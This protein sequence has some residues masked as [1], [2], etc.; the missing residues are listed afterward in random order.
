MPPIQQLSQQVINQIAAGE[1]IER[2]A[3]VVKELLENSIDA[4]AKRID[5]AIVKGGVES[6]KI[7]DDGCGI[8]NDQLVLA[9]TS[10]A[11][12]KIR[13][14]QELFSVATMGFRGEALA[15]IGSVSHM[16]ISSRAENADAG[17]QLEING[18][19]FSAIEPCGMP[20]GTAVEIRDLFYN[21]PVRRKY[22]RTTQTEMSHIVEAFARVALAHCD[23]HFILRHNDKVVHDLPCTNNWCQRIGHFF[24]QE[25]EQSLIP[26]ESSDGDVSISGFVADPTQ[27]RGNNKLQYL[28]LNKRHIKDR[29]LQHALGE[30]YRG[31]LLT[32]RYPI[33]FLKLIVPTQW[34]DV[35]VHP[36]KLEVRF[37]DASRIYSQLLGTIREKFLT[38]DLTAKARLALDRLDTNHRFD[39]RSANQPVANAH[40]ANVFE[41]RQTANATEPGRSANYSDAQRNIDFGPAAHRD[42]TSRPA[43]SRNNPVP[44]GA[45]PTDPFP[46]RGNLD[47]HGRHNAEDGNHSQ[48]ASAPRDNASLTTPAPWDS[49]A[50]LYADQPSQT[51]N[52]GRPH[53]AANHTAI[54][55]HRKYLVTESDDGMVVIDQHALHE[56]ILYEQ[57]REKVL[58]GDL[59]TQA[60]LVPEPVNLS[61][62]ELELV[63]Q[64]KDQLAQIG[65]E[66]DHFGGKSVVVTGYP[67]MLSNINPSELLRFVLD[68][69]NEG[70]RKLEKRD[71][72]DE[73]LHMI[74]CKAAIKAGDALAPEEIED[75]L[76]HRD[77]CQ[78]AHHCPHG[79]PTALVFSRNE[80]DRR[81]K[82]I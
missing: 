78:D 6:I 23:V 75:L 5:I 21:T 20:I 50:V 49:A 64:C 9:A 11:T 34:V 51:Q 52:F 66:V 57:I 70:D 79:R 18:G 68:L 62:S 76:M 58:A 8:E 25:I 26:I 35:N 13:D 2:P 33:G 77:L 80:L 81:F 59:E 43:I 54:Q 65:I 3:S 28:F 15:S 73:L 29:S 27:S 74:S 17:A 63:L 16:R 38:T 45:S 60:L 4:G 41:N 42:W 36:A 32:G 10:H 72:L 82:R 19:T 24:G 56:R 39:E 55:V 7:S 53:T 12:S 40:T 1:V 37:Q 61:P 44:Q 48:T 14:T 47:A 30:A 69:L 22:L 71:I 67:A 31:L 46:S